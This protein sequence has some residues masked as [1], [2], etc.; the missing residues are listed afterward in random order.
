MSSH[1]LTG[2]SKAIKGVTLVELVISIVIVGAAMGGMLS[3]FGNLAGNSASGLYQ[4]RQI[5]L[6]QLY[7]DEILSKHY[8]EDTGVGGIPAS[9]SAC[10]IGGADTGESRGRFDDVDDYHGLSEVPS[11]S[12]GVFSGSS[13]YDQYLV[14]VRVVCEGTSLI[15]A[16]TKAKVITVTVRAPD[17][18]ELSLAAYKGNF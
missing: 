18:S 2:Y 9:T 6:A 16:S 3:A 14:S 8:S 7:L 5:A 1:R 15:G 10:S 13:L 11:F 4:A 17:N 12:N